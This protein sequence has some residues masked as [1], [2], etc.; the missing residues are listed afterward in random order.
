MREISF[1]AKRKNWHD[2][3]K[4]EMWFDGTP[5]GINGKMYMAVEYTASEQITD[6]AMVQYILQKSFVEID[7]NTL[8]QYTGLHDKDGNR[9]WEND[10]VSCE[11]EKYPDDD[12]LEVYPLLPDPIKYRRNYAV[13]FVNTGSNYGYRLRNKSIHFILT[14]NVI[15]NHKIEVLG[16]IFDNPE[17]LKGDQ[18]CTDL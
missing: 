3:P 15:Y 18:S 14:G 13:E 16:N 10:I 8:C 12:P 4:E 5:I 6:F 11:H 9:I 17:L 1:R 2:L 7:P